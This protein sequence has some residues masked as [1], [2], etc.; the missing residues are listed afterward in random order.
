[1]FWNSFRTSS[2]GWVGHV[3]RPRIML[4]FPWRKKKK[5]CDLL[6]WIMNSSYNKLQPSK[7]KVLF[8]SRWYQALNFALGGVLQIFSGKGALLRSSSNKALFI[9]LSP[10]Y[11]LNLP[12]NWIWCQPLWR[13]SFFS[14]CTSLYATSYSAT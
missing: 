9:V 3:S 2:L 4:T 12:R 7:H 5:A 11:C 1:M 10:F 8:I 14:Y 6:I 13:S